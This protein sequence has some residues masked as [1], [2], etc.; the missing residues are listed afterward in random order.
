MKTRNGLR[1]AG[2]ALIVVLG[3]LA[4]LALLATTFVTLA[5]TE[6]ATARNYLD[7]VRARLV[8]QSGVEAAIVHLGELLERGTLMTETDWVPKTDPV[9][10]NGAEVRPA[11]VMNTASHARRGDFYT[12]RITDSSSQLNVNDGVAMGRDHA[13][14]RNLRRLLN[15]MAGH[16]ALQRVCRAN[17]AASRGN[18]RFLGLLPERCPKADAITSTLCRS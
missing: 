15:L 14:S 8:A 12:L 11:G 9:R 4:V 1:R 2:M 5:E 16:K 3:V 6:R 13:V 18:G 10:V 7:S 17:M